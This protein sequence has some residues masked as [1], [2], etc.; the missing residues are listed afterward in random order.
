MLKVLRKARRRVL[1]H[2]Q[3]RAL[4]ITWIGRNRSSWL[5]TN[6]AGTSIK[7]PRTSYSKTIE[8]LAAETNREGPQ[9]LWEGYAGN[10][11]RGATRLPSDVRTNKL[12]G[13]FYSWLVSTWKPKTI[14]EFGTAFGVSGMYFL[15]GIEANGQGELYTFDPNETWHKLALRCLS[16]ISQRYTSVAGT[17]EDNIDKVLPAGQGIDLAFIDAIH[18]SEF[19]KPQLELV[20]ARA[21]DHALVILDDIDFSDDMRQCWKEVALDPRFVASAELGTRV[22]LV[23]YVRR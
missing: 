4:A 2:P 10:N 13:D 12:T 7:P 3:Q 14:V 18:T 21:S 6:I 23:E 16:G 19:V 15:A 20:L 17:F 22:G 11:T 8:G 9:P 1:S 5:A